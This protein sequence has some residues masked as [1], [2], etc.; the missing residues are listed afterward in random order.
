MQGL[1]DVVFCGDC[2]TSLISDFHCGSDN[3]CRCGSELF[4]TS[5]C[6][7]NADCGP[8]ESCQISYGFQTAGATVPFDARK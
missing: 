4:R 1:G 3:R 2:S 7:K 8:E 6:A 5:A